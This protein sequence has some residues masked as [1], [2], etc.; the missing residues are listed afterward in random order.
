MVTTHP[1][2]QCHSLEDP[3]PELYHRENPRFQVSLLPVSSERRVR[4]QIA[5][6]YQEST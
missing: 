1:V 4:Q 3:N 2:A 6:I 5:P